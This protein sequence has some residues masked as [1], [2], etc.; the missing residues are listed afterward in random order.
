MVA[1]LAILP[2][3]RPHEIPCDPSATAPQGHACGSHMFDTRRR[4]TEILIPS[5]SIFNPN[6]D[7]GRVNSQSL[8]CCAITAFNLAWWYGSTNEAPAKCITS[9]QAVCPSIIVCMLRYYLS[10]RSGSL[11]LN[12][13][14]LYHR[15][16]RCV[17]DGMVAS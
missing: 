12:I 4:S 1:S 3:P 17:G 14:S 8:A 11:A 7:V 10:A 16:H 9:P 15:F 2:G 13:P 6:D 5:S